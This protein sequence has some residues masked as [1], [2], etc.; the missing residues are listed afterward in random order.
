VTYQSRDTVG[1]VGIGLLGTAMAE[2]LLAAG[3]GVDG[4]DLNP[5]ATDGLA[6]SGGRAAENACAVAARCRRVILSLPSSTVAAE[7]IAGIEPHLQANSIVIDTTTGDPDHAET[8][9]ARLTA[10]NVDYLDATI[11]GSSRQVLSGDCIVMCGGSHAAFETCGDIFG[12]IATKV[13]YLGPCGSGS[14]MKLVFN[15]VLGLNR[16]VLAEGLSYAAACGIEPAA[17]LEV[18]RAGPGYSRV[19]DVKGEKMLSGDYTPE[20]RLA[21]HHKDLR[22]ILS[23]AARQGISLPLSEVH[24]HLLAAAEDAGLGGEDNSAVYE[25]FRRKLL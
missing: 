6:K 11:G 22:L 19:M 12:A 9:G 15:L 20:A 2:R 7:V 3:F 13:F 24:D 8:L 1:L 4:F 5:Q 25:V 14:R 21:Q 10:L 17:A 23:T 16:A 18:L